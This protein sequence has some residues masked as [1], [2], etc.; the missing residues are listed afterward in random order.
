MPKPGD[1]RCLL[2]V[3]NCYT[4]SVLLCADLDCASKLLLCQ[5]GVMLSSSIH[6]K[7]L[8]C[9]GSIQIWHRGLHN[10][11]NMRVSEAGVQQDCARLA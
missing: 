11:G 2:M 10:A 4:S 3:T 8:L 9:D 6:S 5:L 1:N 7:L